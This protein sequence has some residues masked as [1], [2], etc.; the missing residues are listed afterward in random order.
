MQ[1]W[2]ALE[3]ERQLLMWL[4]TKEREEI[5]GA[6]G[7]R[8]AAAFQ[9]V[10][11]VPPAQRLSLAACRRE[12]GWVSSAEEQLALVE[13]TPVQQRLYE[14]GEARMLLLDGTDGSSSGAAMRLVGADEQARAPSRP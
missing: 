9:A 1:R 4:W 11:A 5:R 12:L 3:G 6:I 10:S 14:E 2:L 7:C 8:R 13:S